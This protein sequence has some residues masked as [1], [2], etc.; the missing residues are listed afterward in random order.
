MSQSQLVHPESSTPSQTS[1]ELSPSPIY[2]T[3][4]LL[5]PLE[6]LFAGISQIYDSGIVT[7]MGPIHQQLEK[8]LHEK[9]SGNSFLIYNSGTTA[10]MAALFALDLP[11]GS[12]VITTPFS[13]AA[14][15]HVISAL[16]LIPVFADIDPLYMTLDPA[17]IKEKITAKTSCILAVHVYGY[18]CDVK[19]I[20]Q[21]AEEHDLKVV[22]D[23]A[24]AFRLQLD[25]VNIAEFGDASAFSFHATKLF[26][27]IEG[28]GLALNI[29]AA[30]PLARNYRNFGIINEDQVATVGINGKMNEFNALVGLLNLDLIEAEIDARRAI[31]DTYQAVLRGCPFVE[32]A[33][34]PDNVTRSFQYFPIR[35]KK[36]RELVY[37]KLKDYNIFSRRYFSPLIADFDCYKDLPS[38]AGLP[39]ARRASE[40]VLCLPYHGELN[41]GRA[42]MIA[43]AVVTI[44]T[45]L[46]GGSADNA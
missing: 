41:D 20:A 29:P 39:H 45:D 1:D 34:Y 13:F 21:I 40:E 14:T 24:H 46:E 8:R 32:I 19:G 37:D 6:T 42:E 18:P 44:L 27:S 38:A 12:E 15:A 5:P 35:I 30:E 7:N 16:G 9:L 22:Y 28:G 25:G 3:K 36:H 2:I 17:A 31:S 10:L 4:P 43:Q 33:T 11:Q 26:N 23:A